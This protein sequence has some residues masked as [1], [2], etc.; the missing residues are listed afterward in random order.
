MEKIINRRL[1]WKFE[2]NGLRLNNQPGF[3]KG[4]STMYNIIALE[5]FIREG[6]NKNQ[7]ENTYAVFL[8]IAKA[9]DTTWIQGLLYKLSRKGVTGKILGWLNNLLRNRKFC[10]RGCNKLPETTR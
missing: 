2:K 6:F 10:V 3:R 4:R 5:H 7:P 8:D 9:F 1:V